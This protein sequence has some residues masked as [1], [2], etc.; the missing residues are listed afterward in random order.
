MKPVLMGLRLS[1]LMTA[2]LRQAHM[3][4]TLSRNARRM[5]ILNV[6]HTGRPSIREC[7][8]SQ[9]QTKTQ[10]RHADAGTQPP[11][12]PPPQTRTHIPA[13]TN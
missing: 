5:S 11:P 13:H 10:S 8:M 12:R 1:N 6:H 7:P 3:V 4:V 2:D 9:C